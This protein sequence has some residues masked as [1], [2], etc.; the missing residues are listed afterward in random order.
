M[1]VEPFTRRGFLAF[2]VRPTCGLESM[3]SA[4]PERVF[5]D[6]EGGVNGVEDKGD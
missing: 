4:M 1:K 6:E 5:K 3:T 2:M